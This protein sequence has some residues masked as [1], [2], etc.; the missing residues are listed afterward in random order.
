VTA[1]GTG[2]PAVFGCWIVYCLHCPWI[3]ETCRDQESLADAHRDH[4][5]HLRG[6]VG[7]GRELVSG[8]M[9][10]LLPEPNRSAYWERQ[11]GRYFDAALG[12]KA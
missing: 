12:E 3:S 6:L 5:E 4:T 1:P 10:E 2:G 8:E 7:A 9:A 11:I